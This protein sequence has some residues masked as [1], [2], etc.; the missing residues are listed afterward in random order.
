M[1]PSV[2]VAVPVI[3]RFTPSEETTCG[4]GQVAIGALP[5]LQVKVTTTLVLFQ[6]L[7]LGAGEA[8]VVMVGG[9]PTPKVGA[10]LDWPETLTTTGPVVAPLG[11]G[12]II[13][14]SLQLVGTAGVLLKVMVLEL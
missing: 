5:A 4:G 7:A 8:E 14:V 2:S 3:A 9:V 1:V 11:T 12:T 13:C 10:L 6:P